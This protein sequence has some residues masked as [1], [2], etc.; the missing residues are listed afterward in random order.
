MMLMRVGGLKSNRNVKCNKFFFL[1]LCIFFSSFFLTG[2]VFAE[3]DYVLPYPGI[4]PGSYYY[5]FSQSIDYF[6]NWWSFGNLS[7]FTYHLSM[8][9]K[10]LVEAKTLFEYRQ[11]LLASK[12]LS[13]YQNHL[14]T[15]D[16]FLKNA[17]EEGKDTSQKKALF[18][19]AIEKHNDVLEKI[20]SDTPSVFVWQPERE[21]ATTIE[22]HDMIFKAIAL[23][24]TYT[25][26]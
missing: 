11:Y 19:K 12:A 17:K 25:G 8:A 14:K 23:G 22:I 16:F 9:D 18:F 13:S 26:K 7:Q 5:I 24:G 21:S 2:K 6:R 20:K 3:S 1:L 10:K 15:A 4:M